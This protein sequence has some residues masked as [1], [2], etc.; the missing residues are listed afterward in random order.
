M[1]YSHRRRLLR[2]RCKIPRKA[3]PSGAF[4]LALVLVLI[5]ALVLVFALLILVLI[6]IAVLIIHTSNLPK[7]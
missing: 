4:S 2:C 6:L 3:V 7:D 1:M 5:L